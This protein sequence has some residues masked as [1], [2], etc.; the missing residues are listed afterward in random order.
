MEDDSQSKLRVPKEEYTAEDA[1]EWESIKEE[2]LPQVEL[3]PKEGFVNIK[4]DGKKFNPS[5][6]IERIGIMNQDKADLVSQPITRESEPKASFVLK[7]FPSDLEK[8]KIYVKCNL[9]DLWTVSLAEAI[10]KKKR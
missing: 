10:G 1:G 3:D 4:L 7:P 9:H 6:Y 5:H 8:T 2:H